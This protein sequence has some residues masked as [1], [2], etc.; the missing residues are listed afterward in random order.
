[1]ARG[2]GDTDPAL[3]LLA[4][5]CGTDNKWDQLKK[6]IVGQRVT[7]SIEGKWAGGRFME[8]VMRKG[9]RFPSV[10]SSGKFSLGMRYS[11]RLERLWRSASCS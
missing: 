10:E 1:M 3:V 2:P 11:G 4:V 7:C 6:H 8:A 9:L 5:L